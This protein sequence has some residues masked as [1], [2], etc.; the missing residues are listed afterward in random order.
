MTES[1][2]ATLA[3]SFMIEVA[4]GIE[5]VA[6]GKELG[7]LHG[8][9]EEIRQS[10]SL[11]F[12]AGNGA[13]SSIS[14]TLGFKLSAEARVRAMPLTDPN[15][16]IGMTRRQ[17]YSSWIAE[18][19][20]VWARQGDAV[21]LISSSGSSA[22]VVSAAEL[23]REANLRVLSLSGFERGN[24]LLELSE[25][26]LWVDSTSYNV[27]ESVHLAAGLALAN[28]LSGKSPDPSE[29]LLKLSEKIDRTAKDNS[30]ITNLLKVEATFS[31]AVS[32]G[33][34]LVFVGEGSST[35]SACHSATDFTKSKLKSVALSDANMTTAMMNDFGRNSWITMGLERYS[36][37]GDVVVFLT[38]DKLT[39]AEKAGIDWCKAR[40]RET[41]FFG[42]SI[43]M[44][45]REF[46][47]SVVHGAL[48]A[49]PVSNLVLP[50]VMN[51]SIAD[52]L[53]SLVG[54][55]KG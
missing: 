12:L 36:D 40:K 31:E 4:R 10:S 46:T 20:N 51:L 47:D 3:Q 39:E 50:S 44:E 6:K 26:G 49:D 2:L 19:L 18:T 21:L 30:V 55:Q 52:G 43:D 29:T 15:F 37:E 25:T 5:E 13:S 8:A 11:L 45:D 16:I 28:A 53:L 48:P 1:A 7:L 41:V 9:L 38:H 32:S 33:R 34:K 35:S 22:N 23:A 24:P 27:V 42:A 14:S 17:D 54:K